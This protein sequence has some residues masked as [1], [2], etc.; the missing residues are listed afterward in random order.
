MRASENSRDS[1]PPGDWRGKRFN[2]LYLCLVRLLAVPKLLRRM[3][4]ARLRVAVDSSA[5]KVEVDMSPAIA[6][7]EGFAEAAG[8]AGFRCSVCSLERSG[9][10]NSE[11]QGVLR[12]LPGPP[13]Y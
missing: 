10:M 8:K 9:W 13:R 1:A 2:A 6:A 11:V 5:K 3:H 4:G 7:I 12:Y